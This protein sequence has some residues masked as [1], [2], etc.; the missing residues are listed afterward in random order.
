MSGKLYVVGTPIGNLSDMTPRAVETLAKVDFIAAEDTRVTLRL[1]NHFEIKKPLI[2]YYE[3]NRTEKGVQIADRIMAGENC[4]IVTDAGMPCIS[5]PGEDLVAL[6]RKEGI[7][8]EV[9]PGPTAAMSAI[10]VSGISCSRFCFEGFLSTS[11]KSR[12]EHLEELKDETRTMIFYEAPHKLRATLSDFKKYFGGE[13]RISLCRE[14]TKIHEEVLLLTLDSAVTYYELNDP[15][16]EYVLVLEGTE[17]K[18]EEYSLEDCLE[19]ML[20]MVRSGK[21]K[22]DAARLMA[23]QS[24]YRKNELYKILVGHE[25]EN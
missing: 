20:E 9:V 1:L 21:S 13:R 22:N 4:A 11:K 23:K 19:I 7:A 2:S 14:L 17:K 18:I 5:D 25:E 16:G 15:R 12:F 10:A 6:C 3:H 24:G 8:I